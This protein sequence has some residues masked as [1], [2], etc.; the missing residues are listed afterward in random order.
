MDYDEYYR[1]AHEAARL[2]ETGDT[3]GAL[4]T[5]QALIEADIAEIDRSLMCY[6]AGVLLDKLGRK[7]EALAAYDWG[8]A[9]ETPLCRFQ[10]AEQKAALLHQLDR[11]SEA[12]SLYRWMESRRWASEAEKARFRHNISALSRA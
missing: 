7:E 6:N 5:F 9:L 4:A 2:D 8:I 10:S 12:L 11:N 3:A 1:Q